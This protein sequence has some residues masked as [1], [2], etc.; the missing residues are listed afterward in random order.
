[1]ALYTS[2]AILHLKE[3][4]N[5]PLSK[6]P[7]VVGLLIGG[8]LLLDLLAGQWPAFFADL[9][10]VLFGYG[11]SV[12]GEKAVSSLR[13]L[14]P[15][16]EGI[17]RA[18]E[19]SHRPKKPPTDPKVIDFRTGKPILDDDQFMDAMLARISLYGEEIL[20]PNEKNRMRQISEKKALKR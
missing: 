1:M 19:K 10:G 4:P 12:I 2:W 13:W 18:I 8:S 20:S 14:R 6:F 5:S 15:L 16:E 7:W 11:F 3:E 9:T 17:H